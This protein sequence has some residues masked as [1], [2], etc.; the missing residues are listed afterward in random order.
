M[1][2]KYTEVRIDNKQKAGWKV[3][4]TIEKIGFSIVRYERSGVYDNDVILN[5][6]G[7]GKLDSHNPAEFLNEIAKLV[8]EK[9]IIQPVYVLPRAKS[10]SEK[11]LRDVAVRVIEKHFGAQNV[12][13][14]LL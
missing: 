3:T 13:I 7:V 4:E 1:A 9:G 8:D 5:Q 6:A 11:L 10:G 12:R 2:Q 14:D